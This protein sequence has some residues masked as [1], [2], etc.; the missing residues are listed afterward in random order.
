MKPFHSRAT[1]FVAVATLG[2]L[3]ACGG[4]EID[5]DPQPAPPPPDDSP[6]EARA[7]VSPA[8]GDLGTTVRLEAYGLTP[9]ATITVG[10]GPPQSEYEVLDQ[11]RADS[12]GSIRTTVSVPDWADRGRDYVFV[13]D[14][15]DGLAIADFRVTT[16]DDSPDQVRVTGVLTEEGAECPALRA[17]NGELYTLAGDIGEYSSGDRVTV[18]GHVA[19]ASFCMQGTTISVERITGA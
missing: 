12:D 15:P 3:A 7:S 4:A 16:R 17:D 6:R 8:T 2:L 9:G 1:G 5:P 18:E 14:G 11:V 10:F 19:E 13:A